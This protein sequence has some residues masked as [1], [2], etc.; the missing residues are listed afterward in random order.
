MP[1]KI[2]NPRYS[3]L[4]ILV[5]LLISFFAMN[6]LPGSV[7]NFLIFDFLWLLV[8]WSALSASSTYVYFFCAVMLF[9]GFWVK[10]IAHILLDVSFVE[11]VG[12]WSYFKSIEKWDQVLMVSAVVA[13]ALIIGNFIIYV[14]CK[15]R[16]KNTSL[17][18]PG[19][20]LQNV[21]E[22]PASLKLIPKWYINNRNKIYISIFLSVLAL[23]ILNFKIKFYVTGIVPAFILPF[24]LNFLLTWCLIFF[25]VSLLAIC[26][27]WDHV[28]KIKN[29]RNIYYLVPILACITSLSTISRF[30]Y[31]FWTVPYLFILI[32]HTDKIS[33]F[34]SVI[35]KNKKLLLVYFLICIISIMS[36]TSL[37]QHYYQNSNGIYGKVNSEDIKKISKS[38]KKHKSHSPKPKKI[39]KKNSS[40]FSQIKLLFVGRWVGIEGLLATTAYPD[41]GWD[42]FIKGLL[43]K[44]ES[45]AA[46]LY[47]DEVLINYRHSNERV[48]AS[49]PGLS[50]ILNYS[51]SYFVVFFGFLIT[52]LI[53]S[54]IERIGF[55]LLNSEFLAAQQGLLYAFYC[56][57]NINIP[58]IGLINM[59]EFFF[60]TLLIAVLTIWYREKNLTLVKVTSA[61]G[62][63]ALPANQ[64]T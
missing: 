52:I 62:R 34:F 30:L 58:Y 64:N 21:T 36:V 5:L 40:Q 3:G 24:H 15:L 54:G 25:I 50:G 28:L 49:L 10:F 38:V 6:H 39:K 56:V 19:A 16:N 20:D 8:L 53:L 44:P 37:R 1:V 23:N 7:L 17:P 9:M 60:A 14:F 22:E 45:T 63:I 33:S 57:S 27:G 46:G 2:L 11:P 26:M 31:I 51:H 55:R 18:H 47:T 35:N 48:Y 29:R 4:L 32:N 12:Y 13:S 59:L 42:F 61:N 41:A 43:Q